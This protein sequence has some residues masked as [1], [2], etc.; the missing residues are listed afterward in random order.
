[1][2]L[3]TWFYYMKSSFD[4][5]VKSGF[6]ERLRLDASRRID[7]FAKGIFIRNYPLTHG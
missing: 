2:K 4:D 1:M 5:F 6:D 3:F 7:D